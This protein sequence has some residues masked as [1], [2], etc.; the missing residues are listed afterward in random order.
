[1]FIAQR[2]NGEKISLAERWDKKVLDEYRRKEAFFCP[3]CDGA[4]TLKLGSKRIWHFA[5]QKEASCLQ[6]YE[7]ESDYHL[8][9]KLQVYQWLKGLGV[10]AELE[11]FIPECGQ[12]ADISFEWDHKRFAIEF[13]CSPINQELFKKR[14]EGYKKNGVSPI[15]LLGGNQ[16][17]RIGSNV[18]SLNHFQYLFLQ[19]GNTGWGISAYCP[20]SRNFIF[21]NHAIPISTRKVAAALS[22]I[23]R[24]QVQLHELLKPPASKFQFIP[25]W[26]HEL[27]K[28][29]RGYFIHPGPP[30]RAFL[31]E[32]YT[33]RFNLQT[34]PP[35]LGLPVPSA[36]FIETPPLI[37][38]TYLFL[39]IFR[40]LKKGNT[41]STSNIST[42]FTLRLRSQQNTIREFPLG[43]TGHYLDAVEEYLDLL[44]KT[45][46]LIKISSNTFA[47]NRP[48]TVSTTVDQQIQSE[49]MFYNKHQ[50]VITKQF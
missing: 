41:F 2:K 20:D 10:D 37:W 35:E 48:L 16:I 38:Q 17:N 31:T 3:I 50:D 33:K 27:Q 36:P 12:R 1:M 7:R 13:Q 11:K 8:L 5:H 34:L 49:N 24:N 45:S 4:V 28:F 43:F 21:I 18:L 39:D 26:I 6:G 9:G 29:K 23:P 46:N 42:A 22:L 25:I 32:L 44:V 30:Q 47:M 14:T 19:Q 15:W 40:H